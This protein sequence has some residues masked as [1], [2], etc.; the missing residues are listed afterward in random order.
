M[1]RDLERLALRHGA[2]VIW[3]RGMQMDFAGYPQNVRIFVFYMNIHHRASTKEKAS[4]NKMDKYH[5]FCRLV[6][7]KH[8]NLP[9]GPTYKVD[10]H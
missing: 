6:S 2:E 5:G 7:P 10:D 3:E 4:N 9:D 1:V 8:E